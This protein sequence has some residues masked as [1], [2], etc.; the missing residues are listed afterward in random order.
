[1]CYD[2]PIKI[3]IGNKVWEIVKD[4]ETTAKQTFPIRDVVESNGEIPN[5]T[6]SD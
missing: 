1:M 5:F 2:E 6:T 3:R 4:N